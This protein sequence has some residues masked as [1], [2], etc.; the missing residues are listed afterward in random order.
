M[1]FLSETQGACSRLGG[2]LLPILPRILPL[3]RV[4]VASLRPRQI[5]GIFYAPIRGG[6]DMSV[7]ELSI[8]L[9][10]P[11]YTIYYLAEKGKIPAFKNG[12]QWRFNKLKIDLWNKKRVPSLPAKAL[13]EPR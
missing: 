10:I 9:G 4:G 6:D 2:F 11:R 8:Y 1:I 5:R 7:K 13:K 12:G 3:V